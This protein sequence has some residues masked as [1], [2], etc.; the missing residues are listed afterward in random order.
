MLSVGLGFIAQNIVGQ[1]ILHFF[2]NLAID[3]ALKH[4]PFGI[5][6]CT[7]MREDYSLFVVS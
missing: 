3:I 7:A 1:K 6:S 5:P 2:C 4:P